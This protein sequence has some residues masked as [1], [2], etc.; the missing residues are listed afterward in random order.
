MVVGG[1]VVV[2]ADK[3]VAAGIVAV[4]AAV[5]AAFGSAVADDAAAG[6]VAAAAETVAGMIDAAAVAEVEY[7]HLG[8]AVQAGKS[9]QDNALAG[10]H[11]VVACIVDQ[12]PEGMDIVFRCFGALAVR[13]HVRQAARLN[14]SFAVVALPFDDLHSFVPLDWEMFQAHVALD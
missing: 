6:I 13:N 7:G 1:I 11:R 4:V 10:L 2:A 9:Q 8:T 12:I 3:S 14:G 5:V